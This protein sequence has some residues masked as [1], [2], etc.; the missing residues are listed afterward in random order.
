MSIQLYRRAEFALYPEQ[1]D[2][3]NAKPWVKT[4]ATDNP[5]HAVTVSR[6]TLADCSAAT[7]EEEEHEVPLLPAT[8][9]HCIVGKNMVFDLPCTG[10]RSRYVYILYAEQLGGL[11]PKQSTMCRSK[12]PGNVYARV[13]VNM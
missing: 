3:E 6:S 2:A 4:P 10:G 9:R 12:N 8:A 5:R 7:L 13:T 11:E 1:I